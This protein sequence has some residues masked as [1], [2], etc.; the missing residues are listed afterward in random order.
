MQPEV[1]EAGGLQDH[2]GGL[3]A[4]RDGLVQQGDSNAA[5]CPL[6]WRW[7]GVHAHMSD[8]KKNST[9][10]PYSQPE[11][12]A[13]FLQFRYSRVNGPANV[14]KGNRGFHIAA[15]LSLGGWI[16]YSSGSQSV[17]LKWFKD[18]TKRQKRE[19]RAVRHCLPV[20]CCVFS[21]PT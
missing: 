14:G 2:A 6:I 13:I 11:V 17:N 9:D 5:H 7:A 12:G 18:L 15:M 8:F 10:T 1:A 20:N 4:E 19:R 21:H 16:R 3:P